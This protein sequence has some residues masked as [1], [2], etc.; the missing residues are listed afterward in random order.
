[1]P[2]VKVGPGLYA[3]ATACIGY[4]PT[5]SEAADLTLGGDAYV[6]SGSAIYLGTHIGARLQTGHNVVIREGCVIGDDVS[7]WSNTVVDYG[8]YIGDRVTIHANCY[9]AQYTEID[10]DV[11]LAPGVTIASDHYPGQSAS[12]RLVAGPTIGR[13]AQIGV[14]ATILPYVCIGEG[15]L[16]GAGA[17]VVLDVPPGAAAFGN[18]AE[19]RGHAGDLADAAERV[20]AAASSMRR[21]HGAVVGPRRSGREAD[22]S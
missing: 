3:D 9:I 10:D 22:P 21:R 18:P 17:V 4:L 7:I 6:R 20:K 12:A 2:E 13:G 15:A 5:R 19:V 16:I 8:C 1:M 14:N 11:F